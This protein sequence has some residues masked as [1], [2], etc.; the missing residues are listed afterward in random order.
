MI[1]N[2][3]IGLNVEKSQCMTCGQ[4]TRIVVNGVGRYMYLERDTHETNELLT[5]QKQVRFVNDCIRCFG[6]DATL[7]MPNVHNTTTQYNFL[8]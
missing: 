3:S 5:F 7:L 6:P 4:Q 1:Y 8:R 2:M